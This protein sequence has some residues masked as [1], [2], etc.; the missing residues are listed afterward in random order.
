MA[1]K[2]IE[3]NLI[4]ITENCFMC[5]VSYWKLKAQN[6]VGSGIFKKTQMAKESNNLKEFVVFD[7]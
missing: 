4:G 7:Q 2:I 1:R 3:S 6:S 5:N